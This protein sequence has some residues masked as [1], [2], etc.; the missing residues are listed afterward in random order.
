MKHSGFSFYRKNCHSRSA[1][2]P[3]RASSNHGRNLSQT[4]ERKRRERRE[5]STLANNTLRILLGGILCVLIFFSVPS[6]FSVAKVFCFEQL[7]RKNTYRHASGFNRRTRAWPLGSRC[8][9]IFCEDG[10][11]AMRDR[12]QCVCSNAA[13]SVPSSMGLLPPRYRFRCWKSP[14]V[15]FRTPRRADDVHGL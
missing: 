14:S 9:T 11:N 2:A 8:R 4:S 7:P 12:I 1:Q 6:V 15:Y 5:N 13:P 10:I 3:A